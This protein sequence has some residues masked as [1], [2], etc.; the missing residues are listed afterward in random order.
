MDEDYA[1]SSDSG[2]KNN[3]SVIQCLHYLPNLST[4][5]GARLAKDATPSS[6]DPFASREAENYEQ[7][8]ASREHIS[9]LLR[10]HG[11][12][13]N[14][15]QISQLLA[16]DTPEQAEGLRRR[17]RA[18]ERD[19]QLV[20][21]RNRSYVLVELTDLVR[22]TII[23][24]R[25]GYGFAKP[26]QSSEY[27]QDF[28]IH[29]KQ[30]T[31]VFHGDEVL[32]R[33][34]GAD[35]R[36]K[37]AA[38][39]VEVVA[40]NTA[41]IVGRYYESARG[42]YVVPD[43]PRV[44]HD[45]Q[46]VDGANGGAKEGQ[47]VVLRLTGQ[48][49]G[50]VLPEGKVLEVLGDHLAPGMETD[51]AIRAH[52]IPFEWP[53]DVLK[54]I[55][56][57]APEVKASDKK[58]RIDLRHLP[59]VTI[60]GEDARD[61]DDAVYCRRNGKG[62]RL[63]VAIADVSHYVDLGSALD[64]EAWQRGTSVYFPQRVVPMLPE[65]LSNG[66]CS[67]NPLVDRLCMVCEMTISAAGN[68]SGFQFYDGVFQSHA[69]L[70]YNQVAAVLAGS[71]NPNKATMR[72]SLA[73][74]VKPIDDLHALYTLFA[75]ARAKRGA[76]EFESNETTML[77]DAQGKIQRIVPV[78]RNDAHK[79]IEEC[80]LAAN[81]C[82]AQF[83][84]K[85]NVDALFRVHEGPKE[86][87]LNTLRA[88]LAERGLVL[89]GGDSPAPSHYKEVMAQLGDR[90]DAAIIQTMMLRS[91]S[92]AVYQPENKGHF[93][94]DYPAYTHFTSPIRRYP[95]LMVHRAIR[96]VIRSTIES[97]HVRR[98][99]KLKPVKPATIYPY[100]MP[101]LLAVGE[102]CSMAERRAD[103]ASRDVVAW[104]KCEYLSDR[105]GEE[106]GGVI[107]S[108][109]SFGVFVELN[110]LFVEGLVHISSMGNDYYHFDPAKQRLVGERTHQVLQLGDVVEVVLNNVN[111][112]ERKIDLALKS[113]TRYKPDRPAANKQKRS[114]KPAKARRR[115][116][117]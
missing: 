65:A 29:A 25:D 9:A 40:R 67:L 19:G 71:A 106:F 54:Q 61:F 63:W 18:M 5:N 23:A 103:E 42:G 108:V 89:L 21:T 85:H 107:A 58:N 27:E 6:T 26:T 20:F 115:S 62:W 1:I 66:L 60:D 52:S 88:F 64:K 46:I 7:P 96:A 57:L 73:E 93:G 28:F 82:A 77:F 87:R 59:F 80:M 37:A 105:V 112:A 48:P 86:E 84:L 36:G 94:L 72:E 30:M 56:S 39:I 114:G 117:K 14:R 49:S 75:Q 55:K 101:A 104:L 11:K 10:E 76:L 97:K 32:V 22:C 83:L 110:D 95:D 35:M 53:K 3:A 68:I 79:M 109:T 41:E 16:I 102:Q 43:N 70:T 99:P 44:N 90:P 8:V 69:R 15:Q 12:P 92:Q 78:Q 31:K 111:L 13:L 113:R 45:V 24:H 91:M 74:L 81:V 38:T 34:D 17:L 98:V 47:F 2:S 116:K 4:R 100:D 51:V 50:H 33:P